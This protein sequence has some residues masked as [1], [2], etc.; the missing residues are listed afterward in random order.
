MI[1]FLSYWKDCNSVKHLIHK[2]QDK[3]HI[4]KLGIEREFIFKTSF[5][6]FLRYDLNVKIETL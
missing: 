5:W 4:G 6:L 3:N 2:T 1:T